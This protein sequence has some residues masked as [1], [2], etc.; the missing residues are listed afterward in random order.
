MV[1]FLHLVNTPHC[2]H[3][4]HLFFQAFADFTLKANSQVVSYLSEL[5]SFTATTVWLPQRSYSE[6][7]NHNSDRVLSL[8]SLY[9][10]STAEYSPLNLW[11]TVNHSQLC[12]FLTHPFSRSTHYGLH[13]LDWKTKHYC[14]TNSNHEGMN[15]LELPLSSLN[16][17]AALRKAVR[18]L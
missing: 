3:A 4:A 15:P 9:L 16:L 7:P 18:S 11:M 13:R 14:V 6:E 5:C 10:K 2:W 1:G 8:L 17:W 12:F